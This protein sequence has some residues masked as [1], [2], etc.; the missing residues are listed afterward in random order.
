M[1]RTG[2]AALWATSLGGVGSA[3]G[4]CLPRAVRG[5]VSVARR[6]AADLCASE[7]LCVIP[8]KTFHPR[9]PGKEARRGEKKP[10]GR[11]RGGER[12]AQRPRTSR[13]RREVADWGDFVV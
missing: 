13:G 12:G 1:S 9:R 10:G 5:G 6:C 7:S 8:R 3:A 4:A 11:K 2:R